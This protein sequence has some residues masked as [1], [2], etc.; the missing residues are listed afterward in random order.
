MYNEYAFVNFDK[1]ENI[2]VNDGDTEKNNVN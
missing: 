2:I 1:V